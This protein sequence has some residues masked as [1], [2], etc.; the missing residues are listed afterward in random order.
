VNNDE[1]YSFQLDTLNPFEIQ[2]KSRVQCRYYLDV[3]TSF[4]EKLSAYNNINIFKNVSEPCNP[5]TFFTRL[6]TNE[7]ECNTLIPNAFVLPQ[8]FFKL[9]D[10]LLEKYPVSDNNIIDDKFQ[11]QFDWWMPTDVYINRAFELVLPNTFNDSV[12]TGFGETSFYDNTVQNSGF[13]VKINDGLNVF[14]DTI[15]NLEWCHIS[16]GW[17][18][19]YYNVD[20]VTTTSSV[21]DIN[22][23]FAAS[24]AFSDSE[25]NIFSPVGVFTGTRTLSPNGVFNWNQTHST[26]VTGESIGWDVSD[27]NDSFLKCIKVK[28]IITKVDA[29]LY[30]LNEYVAIDKTYITPENAS[31]NIIYSNR[32]CFSVDGEKSPLAT[33]YDI[34]LGLSD[35]FVGFY[36]VP[37]Q[38]SRYSDWITQISRV[39]V[40]NYILPTDY[41]DARVDKYSGVSS[42]HFNTHIFNFNIFKGSK[43]FLELF[44]D[45]LFDATSSIMLFDDFNANRT[46]NWATYIDAGDY[47]SFAVRLP[48]RQLQYTNVFSYNIVTYKNKKAFQVINRFEDPNAIPVESDVISANARITQ[49]GDN[50]IVEDGELRI[51]E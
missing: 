41:Y 47:Y 23:T 1:Q 29:E 32:N 27:W 30:E 42:V 9:K 7:D 38:I 50:R 49:E 20:N 48:D 44:S 31:L 5:G 51:I 14:D 3:T 6:S 13:S 16:S 25:Q 10:M 19:E 12:L 33:Q 34:S 22:E 11:T 8:T 4:V 28:N 17:D 40:N 46:I 36:F 43:L 35:G 39:Y 15:M 24:L 26:G 2:Y 37:P 21:I 45:K 18:S